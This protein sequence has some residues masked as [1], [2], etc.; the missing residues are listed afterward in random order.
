MLSETNVRV[1]I[2]AS[3]LT[4]ESEIGDRLAELL[5]VLGI[6]HGLA[7]QILRA[8]GGADAQLEAAQV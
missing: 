8:P 7:D 2:C 1:V 5:A 4:D 3:F 6:L